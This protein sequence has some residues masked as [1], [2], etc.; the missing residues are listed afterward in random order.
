MESNEDYMSAMPLFGLDHPYA[1]ERCGAAHP[2]LPDITCE[3]K[4]DHGPELLH[5]AASEGYEFTIY[6]RTPK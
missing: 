1:M 2:E 4:A 3:R 6:W 5:T